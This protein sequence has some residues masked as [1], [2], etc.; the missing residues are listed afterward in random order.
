MRT[1]PLV[2]PHLKW[3]SLGSKCAKRLAFETIH[4]ICHQP[5]TENR[6][7]FL[8]GFSAQDLLLHVHACPLLE[9]E[10]GS[11]SWMCHLSARCFRSTF[12]LHSTCWMYCFG[13]MSWG[14]RLGGNLGNSALRQPPAIEVLI[15]TLHLHSDT[16][17]EYHS[18]SEER[19]CSCAV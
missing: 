7:H 10:H 8:S 19:Y 1:F 2:R 12:S 11:I 3:Q 14:K 17:N 9:E 13:S 16:F 15:T 4:G 18:L 5:M 6:T